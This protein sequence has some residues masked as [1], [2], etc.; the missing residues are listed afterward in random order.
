MSKSRLHP[1]LDGHWN[2]ISSL[3]ILPAISCNDDLNDTAQSYRRAGGGP[4]A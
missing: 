3:H 1:R 2:V 4:F